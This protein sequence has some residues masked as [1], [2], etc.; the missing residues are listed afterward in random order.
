MPSAMSDGG[1]APGTRS[2]LCASGTVNDQSLGDGAGQVADQIVASRLRRKLQRGDGVRLR[3]QA[4]RRGCGITGLRPVV[5]TT[6]SNAVEQPGSM[7][8]TQG[9]DD[10]RLTQNASR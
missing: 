4:M 1:E 6:R 9:N 7:A 5:T 10:K 3:A 8:A 2:N